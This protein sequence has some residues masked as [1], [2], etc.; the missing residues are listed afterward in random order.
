MN[1]N[2][3]LVLYVVV[4]KTMTSL[5]VSESAKQLG[6]RKVVRILT[7]TLVQAPVF[8]SQFKALVEQLGITTLKQVFVCSVVGALN[9]K[10]EAY[11]HEQSTEVVFLSNQNQNLI[12]LSKLYNAWELGA[13]IIAQL[14]YAS[15]FFKEAIVVSLGTVTV[16]Y[17]VKDNTLNGVILMPGVRQALH[18]LEDVLD[19]RLLELKHHNK[20][21]G[22]NNQEAISIGVVNTVEIVVDNLI[23]K[24]KTKCPVIYSGGGSI[25]FHNKKWWYIEDLDLLGLYIFAKQ[26]FII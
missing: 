5:A 24:L 11:C 17:H 25:F 19:I 22:L 14:I 6:S 10:I 7:E 1:S 13:D 26:A 3:E 23:K 2:K 15:H 21:L 9:P 18:Q 12:D 8:T 4:G 20:V 16:I